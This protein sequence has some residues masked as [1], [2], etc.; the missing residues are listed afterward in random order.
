MS[1]AADL[2]AS[3]TARPCLGE[4][5]SGDM[6]AI[7][8]EGERL[9]VAVIDAMGHGPEAHEEA[10]EMVQR[11][12][13][14]WDPDLVTALDKIHRASQGGRG[15]AVSLAWI[16]R[17]TGEV[18]VAGVGNVATRIIGP[19]INARAVATD[20]VIGQRF[21]PPVQQ[22]FSLGRDDVLLLH[23]DGVSSSFGLEEYPQLKYHSS[24]TICRKVV[25]TFGKD[26]DD[27]GCLAVRYAR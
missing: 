18:A 19:D 8:T 7:S 9:F 6:H 4:R 1:P 2:D 12:E 22:R 3:F 15:A 23:T 11:I 24:T 21:R 16:D 27:A 5:V 17:P 10:V 20:G 13:R 25:R 14:A 26:F